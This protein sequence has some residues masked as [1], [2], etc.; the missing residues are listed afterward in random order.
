MVLKPSERPQALLM[1]SS[2]VSCC[3]QK[4]V[5]GSLTHPFALTLSGDTLYWTDWQTRSI[6]A[7]NKRTGEK[8][9]EIL[10]ALYSPMDIQVLSQERQPSC[11]CP[12]GVHLSTRDLPSEPSDQTEPLPAEPLGWGEA[13]V[14][15]GLEGCVCS[16]PGWGWQAQSPSRVSYSST[17][18]P[19]G[20]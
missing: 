9:K 19:R 1:T 5:E 2:L 6:H 13:V 14:L 12:A 4:V 15:V 11:E 8:R 10:S 16:Q 18:G 17:S 3:R 20:R 7:C